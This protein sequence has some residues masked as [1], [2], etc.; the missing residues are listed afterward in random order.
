MVGDQG[1]F[2]H[3]YLSVKNLR[4]NIQKFPAKIAIKLLPL[5]S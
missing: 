3:N 2:Y 5:T 4:E 1:Q